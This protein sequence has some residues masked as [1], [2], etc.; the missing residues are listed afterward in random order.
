M[1]TI[2]FISISKYRKS[3]W[4]KNKYQVGCQLVACL[5]INVEGNLI[6]LCLFLSHKRRTQQPAYQVLSPVKYNRS[7]IYDTLPFYSKIWK[8]FSE[9]WRNLATTSL[10]TDVRRLYCSTGALSQH[11]TLIPLR[12]LWCKQVSE[13]F[14]PS[15]KNILSYFI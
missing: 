4:E 2:M 8:M 7:K 5:R 12:G 10:E 3:L 14:N 13:N 6:W 1:K 15:S 11:H 9:Q